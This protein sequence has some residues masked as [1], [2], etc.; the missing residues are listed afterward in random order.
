[1]AVA[2]SRPYIKI[3]GPF[4]L[5]DDKTTT[6]DGKAV[7]IFADPGTKLDRMGDG[8]ILEVRNTG[9]DVRIYD[10]EITGASGVVGDAGISIA[11]GGMPKLTLVR[12]KVTNNNGIGILASGGMLT[13]SQSTIANNTGGGIFVT[14]GTFVIVGNVFYLN[15]SINSTTG[16]LTIATS[17][18]GVNRLE[19][20]SFNKNATIDG[21]APALQCV[22][23]GGF[24][25]RNN[26]MFDNGTPSN[27]N[28]VDGTCMHV[29]SIMHPGTLLPGIGN[30]SIDP[31]F[32][33]SAIGDLHLRANSPARRN[34]DPN[35]DLSGL[36]A[37]DIDGDLRVAPADVGADEIP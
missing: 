32:V 10:L 22:A 21:V 18:N 17:G 27:M 5:A 6:I 31:L 2:A 4:T 34:A 29:Y 14:N 15:G 9:A 7:T 16:G 13:V 24:V 36:A 23:G 20:N 30:S 12:A 35:S 19:F 3:M 8:V 28:Q 33:N 11:T 26:I 1:M 37:R 25:A